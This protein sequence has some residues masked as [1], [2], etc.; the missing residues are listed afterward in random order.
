[1]HKSLLCAAVLA[2]ACATSACDLVHEQKRFVVHA[3]VTDPDDADGQHGRLR[4]NV[5]VGHGVD[6]GDRLRK[7]EIHG[8]AS[9]QHQRERD[10]RGDL[11]R[12]HRRESDQAAARCQDRR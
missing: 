10:V 3:N 4:R 5:V 11:R 6:A 9:E 7:R 8:D 1:M 2:L 12:Q